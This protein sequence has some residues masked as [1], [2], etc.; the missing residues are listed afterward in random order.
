MDDSSHRAVCATS[1]GVRSAAGFP[2][3][4]NFCKAF[5]RRRG[6]VHV[7]GLLR[8]IGGGGLVSVSVA[9]PR[10]AYLGQ[11]VIQCGLVTWTVPFIIAWTVVSSA[12]VCDRWGQYPGP[13]SQWAWR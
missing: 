3:A 11:S 9:Q 5:P 1:S 2:P 13:T 6:R 4:W 10:T 12:I 8:A 7:R